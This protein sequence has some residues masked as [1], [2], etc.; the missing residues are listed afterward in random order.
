[1]DLLAALAE[2]LRIKNSHKL[3]LRPKKA[4]K[5]KLFGEIPKNRPVFGPLGPY[6]PRSALKT[7]LFKVDVFGNFG[8][9]RRV[10]TGLRR[11]L[12]FRPFAWGR[13]CLG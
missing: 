2:F 1:M 4:K 13:G 12:K 10:G 6:G 8:Q 5:A 7:P 3:C 11:R 9:N